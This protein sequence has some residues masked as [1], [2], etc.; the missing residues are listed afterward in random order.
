MLPAPNKIR[1]TGLSRN[2]L[3]Q[4]KKKKLLP[5]FYNLI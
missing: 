2:G 4:K 1:P 3:T 5:P